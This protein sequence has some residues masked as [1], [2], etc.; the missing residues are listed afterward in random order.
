MDVPT[1]TACST[2][3]KKLIHLSHIGTTGFGFVFAHAYKFSPSGIG[4]AFGQVMVSHH[5]LNIQCFQT[6]KSKISGYSVAQLMEKVFSLVGRVFVQTC[7]LHLGLGFI[8]G[9]LLFSGKPPLCFGKFLL[10]FSKILRTGNV[11]TS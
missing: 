5:A 4:N 6:D 9:A 10:G 2:G 3:G 1:P 11:F 8:G 7:N